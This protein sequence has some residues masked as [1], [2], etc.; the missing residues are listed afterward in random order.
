M[1]IKVSRGEKIFQVFNYCFLTLVAL[2]CLYP[3]WHVLMGSFSKGTRLETASGLSLWPLGFSLDAYERVFS[4]SLI[5]SCYRNT[6]F[7]IVT[8]MILQMV[9]TTIA[10]YFFSRKKVMFKKPLMLFLLFTMYVEGGTIPFYLTLKDFQLTNNLWGLIIPFMVNTYN[11]IILR[12]SFESI[13]DSLCEAARINGAGHLTILWQ[14][15][16]PLSKASLAVIALYYGVAQWN[17]W[18]WASAIMRNKEL[19]PLQAIRREILISG[20]QA[21][22]DATGIDAVGLGISI[23]YATIVVSTVP[24]LMIYPFVQKYF[25]QGVMIG[26]VKE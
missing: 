17:S 13:P 9:L 21:G 24:V 5:F 1:K 10:A 18:F 2:L 14:I 25:T 11:L 8:S 16:L 20:E 15:V 19:L 7:V 23:K 6:I 4:N 26:A 3:M 22:M 12:M